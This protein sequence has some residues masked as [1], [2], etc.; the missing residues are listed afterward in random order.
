M[1]PRSALTL[2]FTSALLCACSNRLDGNGD[3]DPDDTGIVDP[4]NDLDGYT[5]SEDCDDNDP[6]T[7]P[8]ADELCHGK[9]NNCDGVIPETETDLDGDGVVE[10]EEFCGSA[11]ASNSVSTL[12]DCS[13]VPSPTGTP[14]EATVEWAMT[15]EMVDPSTGATIPAYTFT[16]YPGYGNI[17]QAPMV[18][19]LTDDDFDGD[20]DEDDTPDIAVIMTDN[21]EHEGSVLRLISGD[22]RKVHASVRYQ[23]YA[24]NNYAPFRYSGLALA[25]ID[26]DG[27][28]EIPVLLRQQE[29][30]L[31]YPGAYEITQSGGIVSLTLEKVNGASYVCGAHAP[32]V[33]D[34][35]DDGVAE[36]IYGRNWINGDTFLWESG[37]WEGKGWWGDL[38]HGGYAG[39]YWNS[40]YHS[41]AYDLDGDGKIMEVV[42]G[43]HVYYG[44]ADPSSLN[45]EVEKY[46]YCELGHWD[47]TTW[48]M[49]RDGY[50]AVADILGD[51]GEP[52]IVVTGNEYVSVYSATP[53]DRKCERIAQLPNDPR[54]DTTIPPGLP[55]HPNCEW[56]RKA[57]GG[58]PTIA[59]FDGD[60]DNEIANAGACYYSV[61]YFDES[62]GDTFKRFALTET[63]DWSSA[64]TGS[65][66]FDF[67]GDGSGHVVFGDEQALYVWRLDD[68]A[69]NPWDRLV[70]VLRD[71]NHKSWTIHEYP[72]V[73]DVDGDGKAEIVATNCYIQH[74]YD[75]VYGIY[76]LG[77]VDDDWVSARTMWTQHA[78][79]V[80]NAP[81]DFS[82]GYTSPNY[83]PYDPS[84][85][86]SFRQQEPGSFGETVAANLYVTVEDPCQEGCGDITV[87]VQ[88]ANEGSYITAS[89]GVVV[90][91]YG[92]DSGSGTRDLLDYRNLSTPVQPGELTQGIG[93]L[94]SGWDAYDYLVA[95][96]DDPDLGGGTGG[97]G[98]SRECDELDNEIEI[99]LTGLCP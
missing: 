14:F 79:Y 34:L 12:S 50:P 51:D 6:L 97:W 29:N 4:D 26:D 8:G 24:T 43:S 82:V 55:D 9:D 3:T 99:P 64:S 60:G 31:C 45:G 17:F 94:I 90:A 54:L 75:D 35:D 16:D 39:G 52:E 28:V 69:T 32:A 93:F 27:N 21:E 22:G 78:Y 42:A 49:A 91:I 86:N 5:E 67:N 77:A 40:G 19:Q 46:L 15:H 63:K 72:L 47:N 2:F 80:S 65:T 89:T 33:A 36:V 23:T 48:V 62:D 73:A 85:L 98:A 76:V 70:E 10:C 84:D 87:Y 30:N 44:D 61:F 95:V 41:F 1:T 81:G 71:D 37:G 74:Q 92:V 13:Y 66:V 68:T 83:L 57:F 25:D 11:P 18:G 96:V 53:V 38:D 59:D 58:Q 88:V 56:D 20:I 7:Y